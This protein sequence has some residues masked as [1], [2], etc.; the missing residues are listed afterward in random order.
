M[1]KIRIENNQIRASLT[2]ALFLFNF[3]FFD[4]NSSHAEGFSFVKAAK[5]IKESFYTVLVT[6]EVPSQERDK[7]AN[8]GFRRSNEVSQSNG[9]SDPY[10]SF[11]PKGH[12]R[13]ASGS[14]FAITQS[15]YLLTNNHVVNLIPDGFNRSLWENRSIFVVKLLDRNHTS[16]QVN[17]KV[18]PA[19]L[20]DLKSRRDIAL[21]KI[22]IS[23][24][25]SPVEFRSSD[26]SLEQGDFLGAY[27][28]PLGFMNSF[29]LGVV[30][31]VE[32][33]VINSSIGLD[34]TF[35]QFDAAI[36]KGNSGGPLF[37]EF[38]KV[39]G[40]NTLSGDAATVEGI[41]FAIPNKNIFDT[42]KNSSNLDKNIID[43][44]MN[45]ILPQ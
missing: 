20:I 17:A 9:D 8:S 35:I 10:G 2:R 39:V 31:E 40:M 37:D 25:V 22:D 45:Q 14:S 21:L 32:R 44:I 16:N 33:R 3:I 38:G 4:F 23:D 13:V 15:G 27:G 6:V 11:I 28:S 42:I 30:S 18:Y 41:S 12:K 5:K 1:N 43:E 29:S 34:D 26:H 19:T 36:N 24:P 7:V